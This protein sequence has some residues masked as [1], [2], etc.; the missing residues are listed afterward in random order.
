MSESDIK[1]SLKN[2]RKSE[3]IVWKSELKKQIV[4]ANDLIERIDNEIKKR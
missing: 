3:L 1:K 4:E 2:S